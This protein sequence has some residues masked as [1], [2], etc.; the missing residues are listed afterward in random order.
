M[1]KILRVGDPHVQVKNL[2]DSEA[3]MDFVI[4]TAKEQGVQTI[5]F[6]GDLFHTHAVIRIEVIDFWQKIFN[7]IEFEGIECRVLVGNHDQPGS[8]EKEQEMNAINIFTPEDGGVDSLRSVMNEPMVIE[9]IAYVPYHSDEQAFLKACQD[10]YNQ[11]ATGLLVAHQT[12]TGAQ[13]ENG[14]FSEEGIDPAL[15]PQ[16][17]IISGHIHKTQQVGKC[18]YPGTPKWDTMADANQPK[19]IWIFE[20]N[21]DGT[22]KSKEFISTE[23]IVTPIKTYEVKEGDELPELKENARNYVVLEGKSAWISKIKKKLKGLA[24]I[25]VK[26]TDRI[27]NV[28][29]DNIVT[30]EKYLETEFQPI[31]GVNKKDIKE[32]IVNL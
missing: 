23:F 27:S 28:K 3:L 32:F 31:E 16:K 9:G 13:Y 30:L 15:V 4:K 5:E 7:K 26:P 19:G 6:L 24:N 20:H 17:E 18:F 2:R 22:V 1:T 14:F 11:G 21:E 12:F 8:K 25:K 10:L 29:K